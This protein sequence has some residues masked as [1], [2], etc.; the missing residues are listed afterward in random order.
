[1]SVMSVTVSHFYG[2]IGYYLYP[3]EMDRIFYK[4]RIVERL[5][6]FAM[7]VTQF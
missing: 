4:S 7:L 5:C 2:L 1:M 6:D 3:R